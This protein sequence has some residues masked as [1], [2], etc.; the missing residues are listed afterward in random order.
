VTTVTV[1]G[2]DGFVGSAFVRHLS[3]VSGLQL[4]TVTRASYSAQRGSPSDVTIDCASNSRKYLAEQKP[5]EDF[6]LSVTHRLRTLEDFPAAIQ[7]HISSVDVYSDLGSP[8]TTRE[9]SPVGGADSSR[10]GFHKWMAEQLVRKY[11]RGWLIVR[12]AGM[13]GPGLRKNPVF[14][15]L[16]GQPLRIHPDSQYQFLHTDVVASA[17]WR[18]LEAGRKQEVFNV[19]GL[20]LISPRQIA[21]HAGRALNLSQLAA[22]A[23]PRV[24]NA[25]VDKVQSV[26]TDALESTSETVRRFVQGTLEG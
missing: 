12:L 18:L 14:D 1:I 2:A 26:L 4:R 9:D 22:E 5:R 7:L 8:D 20:G 25:S 3:G 23:E 15:V 17:I 21:A 6:D 13:V 19:C 11:A 24:V 10:Y 16:H